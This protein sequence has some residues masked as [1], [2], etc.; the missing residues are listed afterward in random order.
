V[1][2]AQVKRFAFVQSAQNKSLQ[3]MAASNRIP[4]VGI[5][6]EAAGREDSRKVMLE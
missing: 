2:Y 4:E 3:K 5:Y 6:I 1:R